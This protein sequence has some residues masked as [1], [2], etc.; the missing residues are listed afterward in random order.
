MV[1]IEKSKSLDE[2]IKDRSEE[3]DFAFSQLE[4][5]VNKPIKKKE[6]YIKQLKLRKDFI[7]WTTQKFKMLSGSSPKHVYKREVFYCDMGYNV[8]SEQFSNRPV[9][10]L[11]NDRGNSSSETTICAPITTHQNCVIFEENGR[12]YY[13]YKDDNGEEKIKKL[14]Y[15][16]VPIELEP[17]SRKKLKGFINIAQ[18]RTISKK[19]LSKNPVAKIT[20]EN[21]KK[22]KVAFN[23]LLFS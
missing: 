9:V 18:I 6:I 15:Y 20:V 4:T 5:V 3:L 11:Q 2:L 7:T 21:D 23:K 22:V 19:R 14:D 8:G 1:I 16:E 12:K 10:I 17:T 13:K